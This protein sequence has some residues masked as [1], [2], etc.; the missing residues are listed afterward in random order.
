VRAYG[1]GEYLFRREPETLEEL[2]AHGGLELRLGPIRG[3][4]FLA[5]ADVKS[6]EQQDWE[7]AIS[8]RGGVEL[9]FWRDQG[10][11]PRR[12]GIL[13]EYYSGPSP[14]GQ[15]FQNEISFIG[16]GLHFSL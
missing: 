8:A 11:P 10:H 9:V 1:G 13:G 14:Y 6:T 2:V 16:L 3:P 5:A 12:I 4:Q 15:F 7:P